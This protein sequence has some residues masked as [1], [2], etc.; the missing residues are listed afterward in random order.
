MRFLGFQKYAPHGTLLD[1]THHPRLRMHLVCLFGCKGGHW[2]LSTAHSWVGRG[3]GGCA[4]VVSIKVM[5][6]LF[7]IVHDVLMFSIVAIGLIVL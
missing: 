6:I 1:Y 7:F 3:E 5:E 4:L 2:C